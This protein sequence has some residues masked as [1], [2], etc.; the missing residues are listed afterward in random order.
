M[1]KVI[2][3]RPRCFTPT[4]TTKGRLRRD[5]DAPARE[6]MRRRYKLHSRKE[7]NE[8]LAP[9]RRY[10]LKQVGRPWDKVFRDICEYIRLDNAVQ[11][12]VRLHIKDFVA[13]HGADRTRLLYVDRRTGLLRLNNR[14]R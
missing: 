11:R 1:F 2:V 4:G 13:I 14:T 6:G 5:D 10:L 3:E 12:H 8:N 7:F 9:L